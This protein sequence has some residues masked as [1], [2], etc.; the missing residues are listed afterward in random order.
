M[1]PAVS[2]DGSVATGP[3]D[4]AVRAG[5]GQFDATGVIPCSQSAG[6]PMMQFDFS[7]ARS[8]GGYATIVIE[9]PNGKSRAIFFKMGQPNGAWEQTDGL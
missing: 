3:D 1:K 5:Q 7:V 4:S 2:P 8:G 9:K 6:Q